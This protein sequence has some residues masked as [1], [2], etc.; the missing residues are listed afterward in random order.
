MHLIGWLPENV[1]DTIAAEKAA[2]HGV[3]T[4]P[5]SLYSAETKLNGLILGYTAFTKGQIRNGIERLA[6]ALT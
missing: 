3:Q 4:K 2:A 1:S 6:K 5:L